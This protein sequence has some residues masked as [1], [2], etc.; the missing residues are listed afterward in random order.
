MTLYWR[1]RLKSLI[2]TINLVITMHLVLTE[3][4]HNN[5]ISLCS[6]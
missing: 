1:P 5:K 2:I 3:A 6:P 4:Y